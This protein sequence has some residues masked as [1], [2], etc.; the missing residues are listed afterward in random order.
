MIFSRSRKPLILGGPPRVDLLPAV[1]A[2]NRARRELRMRWLGVFL[3]AVVLVG[4]VSA[5]GFGWTVRTSAQ[6]AASHKQGDELNAELAK[7]SE[8]ARVSRDVDKLQGIRAQAGSNDLAFGPLIA[9][10]T[11][12]LPSGVTL[13]GFKLAPGPAPKEGVEAAKQVGL[14]GTLTF[15]AK[16]TASQAETVTRLRT[17]RGFIDVDAGKLEADDSGYVFEA[18]FSADQSRYTGRFAQNGGK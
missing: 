2:E 6:M 1:E 7:Y 18:T 4:S 15:S 14:T 17:V 12:V 13:T 9:E 3:L 11:A 5:V 8:A 16:L 10:I